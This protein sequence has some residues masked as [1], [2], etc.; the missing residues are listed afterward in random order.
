MAKLEGAEAALILSSGAAALSCT[1]LALLR[2]SDHLIASRKLRVSTKRFLDKELPALGVSVSY[3]DPLDTRGWRR[4]IQPNTRMLLL[5]TPVLEDAEYLSCQQMRSMSNEHGI[6]MVVD[7]T[8]ASPILVQPIR[9]GADLV[10][11]DGGL[12]LDGAGSD[13][14]G[15]VCGT[16]AAIDE[17]RERMNA[18]G[19]VPHAGDL[20]RLAYRLETLELRVR[21]QCNNLSAISKW[22]AQR[23]AISSVTV[24]TINN[25][26]E[27]AEEDTTD[28]NRIAGVSMLMHTE[29]PE[30]AS[31]FVNR[32]METGGDVPT[33]GITEVFSTRVQLHSSCHGVGSTS[34]VRVVA[35][36]EPTERLIERFNEALS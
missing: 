24:A 18:W 28:A 21:R 9:D 1:A 11:H 10:L 25:S 15:V 32:F 4:A 2:Q 6:A 29:S 8:A 17:V 7:S 12:L 23:S 20:H 35:G 19:A 26:D 30:L 31:G 14:V 13:G 16:E 27:M 3:V 34:T 22:A 33:A 5:E 36:I